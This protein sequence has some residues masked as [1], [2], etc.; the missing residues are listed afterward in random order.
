M[1]H[2]S[3]KLIYSIPF[4]RLDLSKDQKKKKKKE[5]KNKIRHAE[6]PQPCTQNDRSM[7]ETGVCF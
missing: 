3:K 7:R 6:N 1:G 5:I 4:I 2:P